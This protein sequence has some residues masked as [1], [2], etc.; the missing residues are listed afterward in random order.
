MLPAYMEDPRCWALCPA[1]VA[2]AFLH[3]GAPVEA[4]ALTSPPPDR[5]C[6]YLT[7]RVTKNHA[8]LSARRLFQQTLHNHLFS[9]QPMIH[10]RPEA[11]D[12]LEP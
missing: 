2:S 10:I 4:H 5:I 1:S 7:N 3:G 12:L 9:L 6:Y 11:A 8:S